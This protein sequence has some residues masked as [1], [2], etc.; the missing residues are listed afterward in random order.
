[1]VVELTVKSGVFLWSKDDEI[2]VVERMDPAATIGDGKSKMTF[3]AVGL[4]NKKKWKVAAEMDSNLLRSLAEFRESRSRDVFL[5]K[6]IEKGKF[7]YGTYPEDEWKS[8]LKKVLA[9]EDQ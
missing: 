1:V 2:F 7:V 5:I 3:N 8:R 9:K 4:E 6:Q